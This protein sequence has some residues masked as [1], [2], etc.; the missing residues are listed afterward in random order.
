VVHDMT[1]DRGA[2]LT[3]D[4]RGNAAV[5]E[6]WRPLMWSAIV[7]GMVVALGT[8]LILTLLG[9]GLGMA[10]ADPAS[11]PG[12]SAEGIGMGAVAWLFISGIISF[13]AGGFV[14]GCMSGVI[15][16][17]GGATHGIVAWSLAAVFGATVTALA[18]ST[19]LGGAAAGMGAVMKST[20]MRMP[21]VSGTHIATDPRTGGPLDTPETRA[22]AEEAAEAA[23]KTALWTGAAFLASM[24]AAGAGGAMGRRG[25]VKFFPAATHSGRVGTV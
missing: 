2:A 14:A 1:A 6:F 25:H 11:N 22:A 12:A 5:V 21:Y 19:A 20:D 13:G 7:G 16:T 23:A 9:V 8:Q 15:R 4:G 3:S 24:L 18:G 10:M 17:G